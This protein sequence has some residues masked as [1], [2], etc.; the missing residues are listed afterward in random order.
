[1]KSDNVCN[2]IGT[3]DPSDI[4]SVEIGDGNLNLVFLCKGPK[5]SV[6][7]KQALPYV[8]CIGEAW[9]LSLERAFFEYK[10]L[11]KQCCFCPD[12]T[13]KLY[14]F[15]PML[16]AF[17]MEYI[18]PPHL[19]LREALIL[20]H[21]YSTFA[22]HIGSFLAETLFGSS[23]FKH[24]AS[25]MRRHAVEWKANDAMCA[26]TEQVVFTDPY[27]EK[28]INRWTTPHLDGQV[29]SIK[30]DN[31]LKIKVS[32]LKYKFVHL[33]EA[34]VHGD[35]HTG[36]VMA[37]E[38]STYCIDP[39]FAFYG[40]MGFDIGAIVANLILSY[41]SQ[42]GLPPISGGES[43]REEHG[44]WI[45]EQMCKL[46]NTFHCGFLEMWNETAFDGKCDGFSNALFSSE[47][48]KEMAQF[49]YMKNLFDES[50]GFAGTKMIRRIIGVSHVADMER[51]E[52]VDLKAECESHAIKIALKLIKESSSYKSIEEVAVLA[53]SLLPN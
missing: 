42:R 5:A 4:V 49:H 10:A 11:Q 47:E 32:S 52:D 46:Y 27:V 51:I 50:I 22:L 1:M 9:P 25:E 15:D 16:S 18:E 40:P 31:Q 21:K 29:Q 23:I 24:S 33:R 44:D 13:P 2:L 39:E 43:S 37:K 26:L 36:S 35:L 41:C 3:S 17:V 8:R 7:V 45:L 12:Y 30:S 19:I 14:H 20:G 34:L 28:D 48:D 6:I 38:G 53:K